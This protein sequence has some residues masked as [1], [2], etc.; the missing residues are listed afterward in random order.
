MGG[1]LKNKFSTKQIPPS[2]WIEKLLTVMA[3]LLQRCICWKPSRFP[4][5]YK[6]NAF[7]SD[8]YGSKRILS[9]FQ[10]DV[11]L[12]KHNFINADY[13]NRFSFSFTAQ[14]TKF[15]NKDSFS[16]CD[17]ICNFLRIRSHYL[18]KSS[19]KNFSFYTVLIP[20]K[21]FGVKKTLHWMRYHIAMK[22]KLHL[23][24]LTKNSKFLLTSI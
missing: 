8:L 7:K 3:M 13:P 20:P 10:S 16:E 4:E 6:R 23:N 19:T 14:K 12:I 15:S 21:S 1:P 22:T 2:F 5:Y 11:Q 9:N 17:Q 18:K 24:I